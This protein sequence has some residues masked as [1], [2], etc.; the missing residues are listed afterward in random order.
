MITLLFYLFAGI[1]L[2]GAVS[3]IISKNLLHNALFLLLSLLGVAGVYVFAGAD[4]M[5]VSQIMVYVGGVLVLLLFG[6]MYTNKK[7][8]DMMQVG[9]GRNWQGL[10]VGGGFAALLCYAIANASWLPSASDAASLG[11]TTPTLGISLMT[12]HI[13][14]FEAVA[15]LLLLAL[16]GAINIAAGNRG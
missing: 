4:F 13:L 11:N 8:A 10:L 5:A 6:V 12:T 7:R 9:L 3:I 14:A 2:L 1:S 16:I 15:I